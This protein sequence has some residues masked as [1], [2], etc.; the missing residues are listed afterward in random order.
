MRY[1][2]I[3]EEVLKVCWGTL[4]VVIDVEGELARIDY[5]DGI[6]REAVIGVTEDRIRRG[7][8]VIV[9]AGVIVSKITRE[10]LL[11]QMRFLEETLGEGFEELLMKYSNILVLADKISGGDR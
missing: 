8:I 1:T 6:L 9:H 10:G 3:Q 11:E 4:A 5:G 7:D 2:W